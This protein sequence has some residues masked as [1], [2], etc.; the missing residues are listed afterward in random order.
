MYYL[1]IHLLFIITFITITIPIHLSV[2]AIILILT[3]VVLCYMYCP[4][5]KDLPIDQQ[6]CK[7]Q[8]EKL[9]P[10]QYEEIVVGIGF[11]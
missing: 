8:Y 7:D 10:M 1:I 9:G 3:W 11:I 6:Y 4:K 2:S 5:K